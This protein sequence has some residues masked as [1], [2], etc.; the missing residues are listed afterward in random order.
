MEMGKVEQYLFLDHRRIVS[1]YTLEL[2]DK[3]II[4]A[5]KIVHIN[6]PKL[7]QFL[8]LKYS[9][10]MNSIDHISKK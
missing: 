7:P 10:F 8:W 2:F 6:N 1:G 9:S 4:F 3:L 5:T